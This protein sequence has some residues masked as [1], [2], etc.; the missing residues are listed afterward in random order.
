MSLKPFCLEIKNE[1]LLLGS[2]VEE[3]V[4]DSAQALKDNDLERSSQVILNDMHINRQRF[5]IEISIVGL[6]PSNSP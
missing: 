5:E 4:M 6:M 3:A 1:V 2:M